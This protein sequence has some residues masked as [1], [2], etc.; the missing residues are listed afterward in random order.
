MRCTERHYHCRSCGHRFTLPGADLSFAYGTFLGVSATPQAA[1]LH[2]FDPTYTEIEALVDDHRRS[3]HLPPVDA[4]P[5]VRSVIGRVFDPDPTGS[6]FDFTGTHPCPRCASVHVNS[7]ETALP[8]PHTARPA[9]HHRW[10]RLTAP[11][12]AATVRSAVNTLL[13]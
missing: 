1:V 12:K 6:A 4:G 13:R 8:W 5:L 11:A 3:A 7:R 10:D 2:C 9:T